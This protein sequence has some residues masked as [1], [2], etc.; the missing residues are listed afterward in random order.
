MVSMG[1]KTKFRGHF[2]FFFSFANQINYYVFGSMKSFHA[3]TRNCE[4]LTATTTINEAWMDLASA[5]HAQKDGGKKCVE[6]IMW[7]RMQCGR[8]VIVISIRMARF[9]SAST[10]VSGPS[11]P[12]DFF[13]FHFSFGW[14]NFFFVTSIASCLALECRRL[15]QFACMAFAF[16]I[17]AGFLTHKFSSHSLTVSAS[18]STHSVEVHALR[19]IFRTYSSHRFSDDLLNVEQF[20]LLSDLPLDRMLNHSCAHSSHPLTVSYFITHRSI[21]LLER[22]WDVVVWERRADAVSSNKSEWELDVSKIHKWLLFTLSICSICWI[23]LPFGSR[24]IWILS[25]AINVESLNRVSPKREHW[26]W[27]DVETQCRLYIVAVLGTIQIFPI[28]C[29]RYLLAFVQWARPA[30]P[31]G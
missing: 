11:I 10:S 21:R 29:K 2:F 12:T 16:G 19:S 28:F 13:F 18:Y 17:S 14:F 8:R 23:V 9:I 6:F 30:R 7:M 25:I 31:R 22:T 5:L 24:K 4:H 15:S 27:V 3:R 26:T 1:G 20:F